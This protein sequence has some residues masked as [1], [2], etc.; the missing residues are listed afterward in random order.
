MKS[1]AMGILDQAI[2]NHPFRP[3]GIKVGTELWKALNETGRIKW[4]H[5][6]I[7]GIADSGIDFPVLD[8]NIFVHV[9]PDLRD[10]DYVLPRGL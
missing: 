3:K 7:E 1:E 2:S 9:D 8:E 10:W 6:Y 4:K 5:G